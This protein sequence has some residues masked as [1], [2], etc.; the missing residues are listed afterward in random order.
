MVWWWWWSCTVCGVE[1][2]LLCCYSY[3]EGRKG[4]STSKS[5]KYCGRHWMDSALTI[6]AFGCAFR[7]CRACRATSRVYSDIVLQAE[8]VVS[9]S[10]TNSWRSGLGTQI[11]VGPASWTMYSQVSFLLNLAPNTDSGKSCGS[12]Y[13]QSSRRG[14]RAPLLKRFPCAPKTL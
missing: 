12:S 2:G 11:R 3:H 13:T 1:N 8:I 9:L 7:L 10:P 4:L 5:P 6:Q 14:C